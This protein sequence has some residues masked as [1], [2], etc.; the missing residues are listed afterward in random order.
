MFTKILDNPI[1]SIFRVGKCKWSC[2]WASLT[3]H[4][5]M[6]THGGVDAYIHVLLTSELV[7]SLL[8]SLT[9]R[10]LYTRYFFAQEAGGPR[11]GMY[12]TEKKRKLFTLPGLDLLPVLSSSP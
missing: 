11:I 10:P 9:P 6:R 1:V 7:G 2:L 4:Y 3:K 12:D 8:I 5:V